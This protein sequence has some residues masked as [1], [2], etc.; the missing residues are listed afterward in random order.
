M[1]QVV[2]MV[3][4]LH[5]AQGNVIADVGEPACVVLATCDQ[6]DQA[7]ARLERWLRDN[8]C[9][10][11]EMSRSMDGLIGACAGLWAMMTGVARRAPAG[12][13]AGVDQLSTSFI[14]S[15]AGRVDSLER[16]WS[17]ARR[18]SLI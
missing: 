7:L 14:G 9:P 10:D 2:P 3:V 18:L 12:I 17:H 16:A 8:P 15:M 13:D 6:L 11:P 4:E 1:R 5:H